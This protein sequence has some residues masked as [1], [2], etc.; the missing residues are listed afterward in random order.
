MEIQE[1]SKDIIKEE[2]LFLSL[3]TFYMKANTQ[4]DEETCIYAH[5]NTLMAPEHEKN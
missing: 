5:D 1:A 4:E 2:I 3:K